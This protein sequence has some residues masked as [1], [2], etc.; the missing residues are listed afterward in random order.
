MTF[1]APSLLAADFAKLGEQMDIFVKE[2][3]KYIHIDV[4][5]GLFVPS[6]S[7]GFQLIETLKKAY[8]SFLFDVHLMI[9]E[10]IRYVRRFA[11]CG[12]DRITVH[13]EACTDLRATLEAINSCGCRAG[14]ALKPSTPIDTVFPY[15]DLLDLI[16][17]M[18]VEPGFGGQKYMNDMTDKVRALDNAVRDMYPDML[19]EV[20]GGI[21]DSTLVDVINAGAG[22]IVS[23]SS[24]FNGD[25][26]KNIKKFRNI[27]SDT[28]KKRFAQK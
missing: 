18:T 26:A 13:A 5:D 27:I 16:L 9:T 1:I 22:L 24:I 20:D 15:L 23:G 2:K 28:T 21:N 4:M 6:L 8:P 11:E 10:P 14:V 12:S 17:V 3:I 7:F 25:I 19:I